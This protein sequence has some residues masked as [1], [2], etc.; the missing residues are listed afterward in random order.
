MDRWVLTK[1][2]KIIKE[3]TESF[4]KYEYS[5]TKQSVETFFWQQFCDNYM[6]IIKDRIYNPQTRGEQAKKAAQHCLY[7]TTL[8]ILKMLAPIMPYITEATY[9]LYF[10]EKEGNKSIHKS[11]WPEYDEKLVDEEAEKK[12]TA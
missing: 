8:A 2:N 10:A 1:L 12:E 9:Q 11:A 3:S 5:K 7:T 4:D 6:E